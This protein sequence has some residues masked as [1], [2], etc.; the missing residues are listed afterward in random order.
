MKAK[1]ESEVAQSSPTPSNPMDCSP[2]GSSIHG[3]FQA[4]VLELGAI[5]FSAS[6]TRNN[7]SYTV[8]RKWQ[9]FQKRNKVT[10]YCD[11]TDTEYKIAVMK[12]LNELQENSER[13]FS[14]FRNKINDQKEYFTEEIKT[15]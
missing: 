9:N 1:S 3:I 11:L 5:A 10:E 15:L 13:Q 14:E 7:H 4:R 8:S 12:K 6:N 2:P